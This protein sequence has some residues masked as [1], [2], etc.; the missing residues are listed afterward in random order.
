MDNRIREI[1]QA[2]G[3]TLADVAARCAPPTTPQ[4]IGRLETG[5]RALS[6]RWLTRVAA[7]LGVAPAELVGFADAPGRVPLVATIALDGVRRA[8]RRDTVAT[9]GE[10]DGAI[11][12]DHGIGDYRAGDLLFCR[13]VAPDDFAEVL[14]RDA[15]VVRTGERMAFGRVIVRD[16]ERLLLL[17]LQPGA[18]QQ[19]VAG[20]EW[21]ALPVRLLR[22]MR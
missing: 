7:A 4:T 17:P 16:G 13:R 19:V 2:Q 11:R 22:E 9:V 18:R 8:G 5:A 21:A 10:A 12:F 3:L 6:V 15:L 14:N 20:P 1:R